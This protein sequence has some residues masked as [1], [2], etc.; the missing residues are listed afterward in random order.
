MHILHTVLLN[1][2]PERYKVYQV[3]LVLLRHNTQQLKLNHLHKGVGV[4]EVGGPVY[5]CL[6]ERLVDLYLVQEVD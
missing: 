6:K 4:V 1:V 5:D 2:I 3:E